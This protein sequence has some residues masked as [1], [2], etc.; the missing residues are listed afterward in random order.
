MLATYKSIVGAL[1]AQERLMGKDSPVLLK[2]RTSEV[3]H[4]KQILSTSALTTDETSSLYDELAKEDSPFSPDERASIGEAIAN[5]SCSGRVVDANETAHDLAQK[6]M[7]VFNYLPEYIWTRLM[8]KTVD[9]DTK[10]NDMVEF[11]QRVL[12]LINITEPTARLITAIVLK[13]AGV[14]MTPKQ[15]NLKNEKLKAL[16]T[17]LR[18][19]RRH[20]GT[21][22]KF[23][24]NVSDFI[25]VYN[26]RYDS[27]H[28]PVEP[29]IDVGEVLDM[30]R[31]AVIPCRKSASSL[32]IVEEQNPMAAMMSS[33]AAR[34]SGPQ[35]MMMA[36]AAN[37]MQWMMGMQGGSSS[38]ADA[39]PNMRYFFSNTDAETPPRGAQKPA[40]SPPK[41]Q[42][43]DEPE[44][45][46]PV[47]TDAAPD[48]QPAAPKAAAS[49][50]VRQRVQDLLKNKKAAKKKTAAKR[51]PAA[52]EKGD[53]D[54]EDD[55]A[56]AGGKKDEAD[57][58]EGE[59]D[60]EEGDEE[61]EEE[62]E[63]EDEDAEDKVKE[64]FNR[65]KRPASSVCRKP[66]AEP[67]MKK[68]AVAKAAKA[69]TDLAVLL[70][71]LFDKARAEASSRGAFTSYAY[72]NVKRTYGVDR[73]RQAYAKAAALWDKV[74]SV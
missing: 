7:F 58:E 3:S 56:D 67:V 18:G 27:A 66:A 31:P 4:F 65:L 12:G 5:H 47:L 20:T 71:H 21:F 53:G 32:A 63:D 44:K 15:A 8:D 64:R 17:E 70:P 29:R 14:A 48:E 54:D 74:H 30:C 33:R 38:S 10:L 49:D 35:D 22:K 72:D 19:T 51:K 9:L 2:S 36:M 60:D 16:M 46:K 40:I 6:H 45:Q 37:M 25:C 50:E 23:P 1:L 62:E 39:I 28:P 24:E 42:G 34:A 11:S 69:S 59:E 43:D 61:E 26:N 55:G 73:A 52:A 41:Q 13:S 57:N 68:P